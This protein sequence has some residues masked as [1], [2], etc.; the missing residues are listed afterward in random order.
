MKGESSWWINKNKIVSEKF[1]WQ[2][3]YYALSISPKE[4]FSVRKY[5]ENQEEH[6]KKVSFRVEYQNFITDYGFENLWADGLKP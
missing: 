6:H 3:D 4:I 1:E 5:I 2:E